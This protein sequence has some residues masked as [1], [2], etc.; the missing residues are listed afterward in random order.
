MAMYPTFFLGTIAYENVVYVILARKKAFQDYKKRSS[1]CRK[2]ALFPKGL[3]HSFGPK[4]A[5]FPTSFFLGK[6]GEENVFY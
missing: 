4:M 1:E 3:T 5:I 6:I 2:I